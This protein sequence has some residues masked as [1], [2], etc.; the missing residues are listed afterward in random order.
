MYMRVWLRE[1]VSRA[2]YFSTT[3]PWHKSKWKAQ[4][5]LYSG[6]VC[7]WEA[8]RWLCYTL[9]TGFVRR[10]T[11]HTAASTIWTDILYK[12]ACNSPLHRRYGQAK[13]S[14]GD[15][16]ITSTMT[17]PSSALNWFSSEDLMTHLH[18][19]SVCNHSTQQ[20]VLLPHFCHLLKHL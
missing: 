15:L 7:I 10:R 4:K 9:Q 2:C 11:L 17:L 5:W 12:Y 16:D 14:V 1:A 13:T 18:N 6:S 20:A 19:K 3:V 8:Y